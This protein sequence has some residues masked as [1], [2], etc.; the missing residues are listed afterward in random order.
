MLM[1]SVVFLCMIPWVPSWKPYNSYF[2]LLSLWSCSVLSF[3]I[4]LF[5]FVRV[6]AGAVEFIICHAEV[7]IAFIEEK[8]IPEVG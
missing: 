8:K 2:L 3:D 7:T 6:G 4:W 1:G 5:F